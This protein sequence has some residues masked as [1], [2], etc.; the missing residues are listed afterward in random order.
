MCP[1][2]EPQF[3]GLPVFCLFPSICTVEQGRI[4][5]SMFKKLFKN[6]LENL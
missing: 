5:G 1:L 4:T 2:K 6:R 3:L